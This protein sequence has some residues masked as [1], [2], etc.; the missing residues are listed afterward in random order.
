MNRCQERGQPCPRESKSQNAR[1]KLSALLSVAGSWCRCAMLDSRRVALSRAVEQET[2]EGTEIWEPVE[3]SVSCCAQTSQKRDYAQCISPGGKSRCSSLRFL[4]FL[5]F[6]NEY[7][8]LSRAARTFLSVAAITGCLLLLCPSPA[9]A[10]GG[11]PLWTNRYHIPDDR[12]PALAN[13]VDCNGNVFVTGSSDNVTNNACVTTKY[14]SS[15]PPQLRGQRAISTILLAKALG[16]GWD[17]AD[18]PGL[19][20]PK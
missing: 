4:R 18:A 6:P 12:N 5:L 19:A 17:R 10:Q 20:K 7:L 14:S 16:G 2:T 11:V 15:V 9:R 8:R 3:A 13:A 1:T